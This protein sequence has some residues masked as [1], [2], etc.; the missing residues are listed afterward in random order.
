MKKRIS[1]WL[2]KL[3]AKVNPQERFHSIERVDNYEAKKLGICLVRTKKEIKDYRKK[4][5]LDE[6]LSNRKSD[7]MLIKEVKDEVRQSIISSIN[8]RGLIEYSVEKV[9][10]ELHVTGEIKV[11]IKKE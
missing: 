9:G 5:K 6:G 10:D 2:I 7:E 8:Q 3:A 11:Y 4:K 1:N